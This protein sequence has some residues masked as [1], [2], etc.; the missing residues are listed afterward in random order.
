[1]PIVAVVARGG[2]DGDAGVDELLRS[3]RQQ[4]VVVGLR[5][6]RANREIDDLN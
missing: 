3:P 4:I 5:D 2:D 1:M 6:G